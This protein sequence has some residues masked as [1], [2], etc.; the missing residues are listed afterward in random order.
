MNQSRFENQQRKG[1]AQAP[2]GHED[3]ECPTPLGVRSK[4]EKR[5]AWGDL[6]EGMDCWKS[7][8]NSLREDSFKQAKYLNPIQ[9]QI[10][11]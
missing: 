11:P 8:V 9:N 7:N 3:G 2:L 10:A 5:E 6:V 4:G 1:D